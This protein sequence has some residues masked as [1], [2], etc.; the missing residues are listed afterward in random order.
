MKAGRFTSW[1]SA[2]ERHAL[3]KRAAADGVH[4]NY[5]VRMAVREYLGKDALKEAAQEVMDVTGNV[6]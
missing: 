5:I 2:T 1:F 3:E 4:L 6:A